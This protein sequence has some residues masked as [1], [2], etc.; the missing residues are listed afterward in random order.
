MYSNRSSTLSLAAAVLAGLALLSSRPATADGY[1]VTDLGALPGKPNSGEWQQTINNA[2]VI[3]AYANASADDLFFN[4]FF[5]DSPFLWKN[6][7]ITPLPELPGAIDTIPFHI[8]NVGQVVG[9]STP[10]G[11]RNH[12]VLWD[13]GII[14]VLPELAGDNSSAALSINDRGQAV[15][16]SRKPLADGNDRH[17]AL[18]YKGT[19]SQ[20]PPLPGGGA[21][22]EALCINEQGQMAGFSGPSSGLEHIALWSKGAVYDLGTLGGPSAFA[23]GINN[24]VQVVGQSDTA[25]GN[26]DPF[27]WEN[28]VLTD[29]GNFGADVYGTAVDINSRSQI[30]GYSAGDPNDML[31]YHALLWEN[32]VMTNLQTKI[33]AVSGWTLLGA[34]GINEH[35]QIVGVGLHNGFLRACLLTPVL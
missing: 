11:Q 29:L 12:A 26:V 34:S 30:V 23:V 33:P 1:T 16:Y 13:H 28:G 18:W 19:V 2:G 27:F 4:A 22:D 7:A 31:T 24:K 14:Q 17:A 25:S 15:G 21:F 8:N 10:A 3:A 6:G 32:G 9:R 5:G 35:G 20:L